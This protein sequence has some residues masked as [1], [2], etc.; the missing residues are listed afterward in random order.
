MSCAAKQREATFCQAQ[1]E[2]N[3]VASHGLDFGLGLHVLGGLNFD[4]DLVA[5]SPPFVYG[6]ML[7][8]LVCPRRLNS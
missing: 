3:E 4:L 6:K 8:S 2:E 1:T 5:F 7:D